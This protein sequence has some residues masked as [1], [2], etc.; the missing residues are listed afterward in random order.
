MHAAERRKARKE[1][2]TG[3][4]ALTVFAALVALNSG[5]GRSASVEGFYLYAIFDRTEGLAVGNEVRVAGIP[6]GRVGAFALTPQYDVQVR[7]DF[8]RPFPIPLDSAA[9]IETMGLFGDKYVEVQPGGTE[10]MMRVGDT[11]DYTQDAVVI[12]E[13]LATVIGMAKDG[14]A[15]NDNGDDDGGDDAADANSLDFDIP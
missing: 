13:L 15:D 2:L 14:E 7:L 6:V 3:L 11:F 4:A 1:T 10:D 9:I 8:A 12:E 5:L